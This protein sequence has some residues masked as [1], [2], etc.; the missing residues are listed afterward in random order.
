M[1]VLRLRH[2]VW[3]PASGK[4]RAQ[5]E[6]AVISALPSDPK[7]STA[8]SAIRLL[9]KIL[10]TGGLLGALASKVNLSAVSQKIGAIGFV[11]CAIC[12][13]TTLVL[14]SLAAWRWQM[15]LARMQSPV[16]FGESWRLVMTG[17]FF[18]QFLPSG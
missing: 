13:L 12:I 18:N 8:A 4:R 15:I 11:T 10:I 5:P 6:G 16:A 1:G 3:P 14:A 2:S 7:R 9:V 17:L